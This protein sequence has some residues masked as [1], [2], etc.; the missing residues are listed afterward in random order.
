MVL[1]HIM[2]GIK[3]TKMKAWKSK[4]SEEEIWKVIVFEASFGLPGKKYDVG[5]K[6]LGSQSN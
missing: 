3:G 1:A 6:S 5:D 2:E 4:L